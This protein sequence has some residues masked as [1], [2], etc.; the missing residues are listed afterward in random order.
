MNANDWKLSVTGD[1]CPEWCSA[2]H[3]DE[4]PEHDSVFHESAPVAV[5]LPPLINGERL[6]LAFVTTSSEAYRLPGEGRS[7][8]RVDLGTESD[9]EGA[10]HDYV[11]VS[12]AETLDKLITDLRHAVSTLEQWRDRLPAAA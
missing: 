5:E 6:R 1:N 10:V 9:R 7:P 8:A 12:S 4:D 3:A 11:P 2:D